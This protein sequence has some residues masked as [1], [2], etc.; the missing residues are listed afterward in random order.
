M[1][2]HL[3]LLERIVSSTSEIRLT[4][5]VALSI[6][7]VFCRRFLKFTEATDYK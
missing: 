4:N 5:F 2:F 6:R 3:M 7:F 1:K